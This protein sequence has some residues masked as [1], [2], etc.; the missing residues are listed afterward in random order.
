MRVAAS[1]RGSLRSLVFVSRSVSFAALS[2][3]RAAH[4]RLVDC[5]RRGTCVTASH[6]KVNSRAQL[7]CSQCVDRVGWRKTAPA[8]DEQWQSDVRRT[9]A[10][11]SQQA[12]CQHFRAS[13]DE[14]V[15]SV[16]ALTNAR[17]RPT[18]TKLVCGDA[19]RR[20]RRRTEKADSW[21]LVFPEPKKKCVPG[22]Q[23][24]ADVSVVFGGHCRR[25]S[26]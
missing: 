1:Q 4:T 12:A 16:R 21:A 6:S 2:R 19:R 10:K 5:G 20:T 25:D 7:V 13:Y 26:T 8:T 14:Q 24:A 15:E 3:Q 18:T 22:T 9:R 23:N 17:R 11:Y